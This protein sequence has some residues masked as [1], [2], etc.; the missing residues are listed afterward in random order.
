MEK[1]ALSLDHITKTYPGV[2]ALSDVSIDFVEGEV[3]ALMGENGAGKSTFIKVLSGAIEPDHGKITIGRHSYDKM[4]PA[5]ALKE[6]VAVIYQEFNYFPTLTVAENVFMGSFIGNG[7]V[8]NKAE[9]AR[10]TKI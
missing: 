9:M 4:T 3:H 10:R 2:V 7:I 5:L 1:V 6:G 8:V